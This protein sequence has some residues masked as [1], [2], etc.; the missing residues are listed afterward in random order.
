MNF[1]LKHFLK[2][3][4]RGGFRMVILMSLRRVCDKV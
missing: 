1:S 3:E 4:S 2:I